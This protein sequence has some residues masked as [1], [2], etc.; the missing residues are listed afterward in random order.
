MGFSRELSR[1]PSRRPPWEALIGTVLAL[2]L[3]PAFAGQSEATSSTLAC[4]TGVVCSRVVVPLDWSGRRRGRV[5]LWVEQQRPAGP[6][7][8]VMFLLAGGPGQAATQLFTLGKNDFWQFLFPGYTLVAFDSRGTGRSDPL[9]CPV[10]ASAAACAEKLGPDRDDYTTEANVLDLDAVRQALGFQRISLFGTSYG[11]ELAL[12][13]VRSFPTRVRRLLLDSVST[14]LSSISSLSDVLRELPSTLNT[15]CAHVCAAVTSDYGREVVVLANLL[16]RQPLDVSSLLPDGSRAFEQLDADQFVELVTDADLNPWLAAVLPAAVHAAVKGAP[17]ALV[18]LTAIEE[19][20]HLPPHAITLNTAVYRATVCNDGPFPWRPQAPLGERLELLDQTL[21]RLP[22]DAFGGLDPWAVELGNAYACLEWP[23]SSVP[24]LG[25]NTGRAPDIPVLAVAGQFD[26][27]GTTAEAR[28]AI[29]QFP[30][31]RVLA[32]ENAGHAAITNPGSACVFAAV[33]RWLT[34][35]AVPGTCRA[36]RPLSPI[37]PYPPLAG[38]LMT[39][40]AELALALATIHEAEAIWLLVPTYGDGPTVVAGL[41]SGRLSATDLD[42][43]LSHYGVGGGLAITGALRETT[44]FSSS[45]GRFRGTLE[46]TRRS[47]KLGTLILGARGVNG[48]L[49]RTPVIAGRLDP[50]ARARASAGG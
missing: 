29:A 22:S 44:R 43:R 2:V 32:V 33:H 10:L 41:T 50:A 23:P 48:V 11:A 17:Q 39:P 18:R 3:L 14:P 40:R 38:G 26:L 34:N 37:A 31:G 13:Y 5:S 12:A 47:R 8:G 9:S 6:E 16:A 45:Q 28:A 7:R 20:T 36:V 27:R 4:P 1:T 46:L 30:D 35:T 21:A 42:V 49:G 24:Y 15:Y 25:A 19:P